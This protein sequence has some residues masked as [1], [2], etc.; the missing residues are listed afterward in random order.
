MPARPTARTTTHTL[1]CVSY[2]NAVPLIHGV[3]SDHTRVRLDVP[4]RLLDDL[5]AGEVDAALCPVI[6]YFR[7]P[8]PLAILPVGGIGCEGPTL[9]VRL[10]SR[11]PIDRVSTIYA[12]TDSH[13]SVV[14][15][16]V[17]LDRLHGIRPTLIDF[18]ARESTAEGRIVERPQAMLLIG[19]KVVTAGPVAAAYPHQIDLGAAWQELTGLPFVFA[20][21]LARADARFGGLPD[22]LAAVREANLARVDELASA[23]AETHGWPPALAGEYL[24]SILRYRV[25]PRE[26]EGIARF[27][28]E[29]ALLGLV[30]PAAAS[31]DLRLLCDPR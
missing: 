29:A 30:E 3:A 23:N 7:S 9:T 10:F 24:G 4:A 25:G 19:D 1:G 18:D 26:L 20:T 22:H 12:D 6:D 31:A 14:L 2:L 21:W 15:L 17:V 13:T 11:A 8:V 5:L 27:A 16:Q 28:A